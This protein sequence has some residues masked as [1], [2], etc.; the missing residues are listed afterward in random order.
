[1]S[2]EEQVH[3]VCIFQRILGDLIN[4]FTGAKQVKSGLQGFKRG[5]KQKLKKPWLDHF[6]KEMG[7]TINEDLPLKRDGHFNQKEAGEFFF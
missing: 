6:L 5:I 7:H 1:M 4:S 2:S 3:L